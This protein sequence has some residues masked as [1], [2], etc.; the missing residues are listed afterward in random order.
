M[1]G[2]LNLGLVVEFGGTASYSGN[3]LNN[4]NANDVGEVIGS[5]AVNMGQNLC[6]TAAC[7]GAVY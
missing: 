6:G 1:V 2:N 7:P 4:G 5:H 3:V